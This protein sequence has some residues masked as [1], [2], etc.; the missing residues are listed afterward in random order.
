MKIGRRITVY[1]KLFSLIHEDAKFATAGGILEATGREL[2]VV[3]YWLWKDYSEELA[4]GAAR[5]MQLIK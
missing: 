4:L 3:S 1:D 2:V 5:R